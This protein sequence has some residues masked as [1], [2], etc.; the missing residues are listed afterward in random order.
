MTG[1]VC[2]GC[3]RGGSRGCRP[4]LT[5]PGWAVPTAF[6]QDKGTGPGGACAV[7]GRAVAQTPALGRRAAPGGFS[8]G[9]RGDGIRSGVALQVCLEW[10]EASGSGCA[11]FPAPVTGDRSHWSPSPGRLGLWQ[12]RSP[13]SCGSVRPSRCQAPTQGEGETGE[14]SSLRGLPRSL[15][16]SGGGWGAD[17]VKAPVTQVTVVR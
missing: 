3:R 4:R 5:P 2:R 6:S 14:L 8:V 10:V 16:P 15:C 12:E 13:L 17:Q 11:G 9:D 7:P 1:A